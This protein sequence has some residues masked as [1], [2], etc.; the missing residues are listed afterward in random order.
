MATGVV[1][2]EGVSV[3]VSTVA[4]AVVPVSPHRMKMMALSGSSSQP[5]SASTRP[6]VGGPDAS[7]SGMGILREGRVPDFEAALWW[8][9]RGVAPKDQEMLVRKSLA[10]NLNAAM[11][12]LVEALHC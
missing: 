1:S 7:F 6:R 2:H 5:R 11:I 12:G 8:A 3:S 9:M 10:R 4:T